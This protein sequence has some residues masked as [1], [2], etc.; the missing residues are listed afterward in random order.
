MSD[1]FE[2]KKEIKNYERRYCTLQFY[3]HYDT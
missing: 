1:I 2:N 3:T